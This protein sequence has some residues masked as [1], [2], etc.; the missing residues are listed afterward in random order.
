MYIQTMNSLSLSAASSATAHRQLVN[1]AAAKC[2]F[3]GAVSSL[4]SSTLRQ[5]D[6]TAELPVATGCSAA[7]RPSGAG[8]PSLTEHSS[9]PAV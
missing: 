1:F 2:T 9:V 8:G 5:P 7:A 3:S 4:C 6:S